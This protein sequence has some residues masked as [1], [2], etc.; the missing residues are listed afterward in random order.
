M[1]DLALTGLQGKPS[2]V[3]TD[4]PGIIAAAGGMITAL[5][6]VIALLIDGRR[7]RRQLGIDNMWRLIEQWDR[8]DFRARRAK[9][10]SRL[11]A[12]FDQ[13]DDLPDAA[14]EVLNTF[15]LLGYLVI[16]SQTLPIEDA[17]INFSTYAV[18]WW[19][20]CQPAIFRFRSQ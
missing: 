17:W 15:E 7:T 5:A 6:A 3:S 19:R 2:S 18:S 10:A 12:D 1:F 16:R 4:W 14:I 11:L 9:A 20:V 13:R 8:P